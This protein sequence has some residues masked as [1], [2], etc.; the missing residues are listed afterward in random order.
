MNTSLV[1]FPVVDESS[2]EIR[3]FALKVWVRSE[4]LAANAL[5]NSGYQVYAPEYQER[6]RSSVNNRLRLV[7]TAAFPGYIFCQFDELEKVAVLRMP[8]VEYIV[9][10]GGK[11]VPIRDSEIDCI[12]RAITAGARPV[13][14]LHI[15]E[16]VRIAAGPLSGL[17]GILSRINGRT[18]LTL[19]VDLLQRS[20]SVYVEPDQVIP[21][22]PAPLSFG[23]VGA[24]AGRA[25]TA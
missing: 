7:H 25:H 12:K 4:P 3:W 16:R 5:T 6:R 15:G 2:P 11:P 8:A 1:Q 22:K 13:P 10:C 21:V 23:I 17:E 14:Y 18:S 24:Q 9:G 19:S 20:V